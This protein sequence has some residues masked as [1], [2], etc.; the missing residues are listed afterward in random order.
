MLFQ[1]ADH[2][3]YE[4]GEHGLVTLHGDPTCPHIERPTVEVERRIEGDDAWECE[5]YSAWRPQ[6]ARLLTAGVGH[7]AGPSTDPIVRPTSSGA[8]AV[9]AA[10]PAVVEETGGDTL[11]VRRAAAVAWLA[12]EANRR[13]DTFLEDLHRKAQRWDLSERQIEC[14]ERNIERQARR[15]AETAAT[16]KPIPADAIDLSGLRDGYYAAT[17]VEDHLTFLRVSRN[18]RSGWINVAIVIG[19]HTDERMG[20]Q[21]PGRAYRG[22][23]QQVLRNIL[24]D[25]EAAALAF[26]TELGTC[27]RCN[28][29]LTDETSRRL[30]IGPECRSK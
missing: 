23:S 7:L 25:P 8:H 29:H 30:G 12:V 17:G 5:C 27:S 4:A 2:V 16:P 26:A 28:R 24:A 6:Y 20:S 13:G 19:G 22:G 14:V 11:A 21:G 1:Y 9:V 18:R 3:V 10:P 15:A